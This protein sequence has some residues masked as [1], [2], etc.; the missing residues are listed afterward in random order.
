MPLAS[1]MAPAGVVFRGLPLDRFALVGAAPAVLAV[2]VVTVLGA[3]PLG[4]VE[5]AAAALV[6]VLAAVD[7]AAAAEA[8]DSDAD[9]A[10]GTEASKDLPELRI[11]VRDKAAAFSSMGSII[12]DIPLAAL[13]LSALFIRS[14]PLVTLP[15]SFLPVTF[16]LFCLLRGF[17][18]AF[19]ASPMAY[20]LAA[21]DRSSISLGSGTGIG[22][23]VGTKVGRA[24]CGGD[25]FAVAAAV[26]V[27]FAAVVVEVADGDA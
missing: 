25:F 8:A 18:D 2:A 27:A 17:A 16:P 10:G 15:L 5:V 6:L 14:L 21:R 26:V 9:P 3:R 23:R 19:M 24:A 11:E 4:V 1:G 13:A 20:A 7:V 12:S 22:G